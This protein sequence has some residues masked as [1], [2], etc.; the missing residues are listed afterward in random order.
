M[1]LTERITTLNSM[2]N[3][4]VPTNAALLAINKQW[5]PG[6][7]WIVH[8]GRNIYKQLNYIH[9]IHYKK[10]KDGQI[11]FLSSWISFFI[12]FYYFPISLLRNMYQCYKKK[13]NKHSL[14]PSKDI[15]FGSNT[16]SVRITDSSQIFLSLYESDSNQ[17]YDFPKADTKENWWQN[18]QESPKT[19]CS[20]Y[21]IFSPH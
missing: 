17:K 12:N 2:S 11:P 8:K 21:K 13:K 18:Q 4:L 5:L 10:K 6:K 16:I 19:K 3:P 20:I 15:L 14:F 1:T 7:W 9:I